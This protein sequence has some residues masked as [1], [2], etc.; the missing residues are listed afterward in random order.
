MP[1]RLAPAEIF[2]QLKSQRFLLVN[3]RR[4]NGL[5]I[6]KHYYAEFAGPGAAVGGT[7]DVDCLGVFPVGDLELLEPSSPEDRQRGCATRR[8][9]VQLIRKITSEELPEKRAKMIM[10][11]FQHYFDGK[12]IAQLPDDTFAQLVGVLPQTIRKIRDI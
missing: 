9:W 6:F 4:R 2:S 8:Q 5:I 12:A 10:E 1:L 3:P 11:Q 7:V